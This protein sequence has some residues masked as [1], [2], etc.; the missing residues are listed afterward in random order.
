VP[1]G[2]RYRRKTGRG[3][4]EH[5]CRSTLPGGAAGRKTAGRWRGARGVKGG[6][7]VRRRAR[8]RSA[9]AAGRGRIV[10]R[11]QAGWDEVQR[12][13]R[14]EGEAGQAASAIG[15]VWRAPDGGG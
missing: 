2:V 13:H 11:N 8:R 4:T 1:V 7:R 5:G 9:T 3:E 10:S 15:V 14:R 6:P 12:G